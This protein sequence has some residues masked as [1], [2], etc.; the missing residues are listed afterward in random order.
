MCCRA[1]RPTDAI[2]YARPAKRGVECLHPTG[3]FPMKPYLLALLAFGAL[4]SS[5]LAASAAEPG[6]VAKAVADPSRPADERKLDAVR[7]PAEVLAFSGIKPGD[8]V[9]EYLPGG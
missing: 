1:P 3:G 4:A 9:A 6:Y 5:P 8:T 2:V 7:K